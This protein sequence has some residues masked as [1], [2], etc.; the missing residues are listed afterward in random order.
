[1]RLLNHLCLGR[2]VLECDGN[3][4]HSARSCGLCRLKRAGADQAKAGFRG[5]ADIHQHGVAQRRTLADECAA[6]D[7]K[8]GEVPVEAGVEPS[9]QR[10][11][12]V[13]GQHRGTEEHVAKAVAV[14]QTRD[15]IHAR[16]GQGSLKAR[17]IGDEDPRG[18]V[19]GRLG[20]EASDTGADDDRGG[21]RVQRRGLTEDAQGRLLDTRTV[22]FEEDE[23]AH[24]S[25]LST[26]YSR[27]FCAAEPSSS[28]F[29]VSPREGGE[30]RAVTVVRE[31]A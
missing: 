31:P 13:A 7:A 2:E 22:V 16:L 18:T 3:L 19:A 10:T 5:P 9:R 4:L 24:T 28:I 15:D 8:V 20:G 6:F 17:V 26:R 25:F 12:N 27:I 11:G 30:F 29:C 1:V 21:I 23:C 14:H